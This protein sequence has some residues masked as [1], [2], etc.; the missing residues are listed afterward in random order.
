VALGQIETCEY[1]AGAP[2]HAR[3]IHEYGIAFAGKFCVVAVRT[4]R[5]EVD[6]GGW[7]VNHITPVVPNHIS[8]TDLVG[9]DSGNDD[10]NVS[11]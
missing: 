2:L 4:L 3:T 7:V 9:D 11:M 6:A 8:A 5:R 10:M 1:R